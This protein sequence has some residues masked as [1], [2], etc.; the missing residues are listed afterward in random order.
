M[1]GPVDVET[2]SQPLS[3]SYSSASDHDADRVAD[4][5]EVSYGNDRMA[6]DWGKGMSE[7][8]AKTRLKGS[9]PQTR[10]QRMASMY[11]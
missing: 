7:P 1:P 3:S 10:S 4:A 8:V 9:R 6:K 2:S 11:V 5:L